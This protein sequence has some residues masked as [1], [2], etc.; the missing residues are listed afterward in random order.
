[1][2]NHCQ[3]DSQVTMYQALAKRDSQVR[4]QVHASRK[5]RKFHA[6]TDGLRS[7]CV[8]LCWVAKQ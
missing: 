1:M 5:T 8:G 6:Y 3:E 7:A 2:I 4:S